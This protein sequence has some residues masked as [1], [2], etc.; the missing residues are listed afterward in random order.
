MC[1]MEPVQSWSLTPWL[2]SIEFSPTSCKKLAGFRLKCALS[3]WIGMDG[4]VCYGAGVLQLVFSHPIIWGAL[5][6]GFALKSPSG[7]ASSYKTAL[8]VAV[9]GLGGAV[10]FHSKHF[11]VIHAF[12]IQEQ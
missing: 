8:T 12:A 9:A 2:C 4:W 6:G 7:C 1:L 11:G 10:C 5:G 3:S